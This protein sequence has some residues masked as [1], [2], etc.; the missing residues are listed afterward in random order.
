MYDELNVDLAD[1]HL[2]VPEL[3]EKYTR[4]WERIVESSFREGC[5]AF[6]E[7]Q[8]TCDDLACWIR[9]SHS[10][11]EAWLRKPSFW[12]PTGEPFPRTYSDFKSLVNGEKRID[13]KFQKRMA[14]RLM[15]E[16]QLA[17]GLRSPLFLHVSCDGSRG[18]MLVMSHRSFFARVINRSERTYGS[19]RFDHKYWSIRALPIGECDY[20]RRSEYQ[21]LFLN[22]PTGTGRA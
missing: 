17:L 9:Y 3:D 18:G 10:C 7:R 21:Q 2:S 15:R 1:I 14:Y 22:C 20:L 12:K 4:E 19:T 13:F 11:E 6:S 5:S 16:D 8:C